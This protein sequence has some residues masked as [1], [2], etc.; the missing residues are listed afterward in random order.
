MALDTNSLLFTWEEASGRFPL[1]VYHMLA[2][3]VS[4]YWSTFRN[5]G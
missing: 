1:Q 5:I 3:K 2:E 4:E